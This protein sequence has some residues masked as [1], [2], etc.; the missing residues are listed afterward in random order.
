LA[1]FK[2]FAITER[3]HVEFRLSGFNF[4]NHPLESFQGGA[5]TSISFNYQ[6][7]AVAFSNGGPPCFYGQ[8]QYVASSPA[9]K[10]NYVVNGNQTAA[11]YASTKYGRRVVEFSAKYTF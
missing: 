10:G 11:G 2:T 6:C 7:G 4:L 5:D 9:P 3:Q 8:G 1:I